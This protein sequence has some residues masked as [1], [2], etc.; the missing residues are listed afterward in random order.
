MRRHIPIRHL[1]G[2]QN[3]RPSK[4]TLPPTCEP[5]SKDEDRLRLRRTSDDA[6]DAKRNFISVPDDVD[7][8]EEHTEE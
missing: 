1:K 4:Y 7:D 5:A 2:D 8:H 6:T 3:S